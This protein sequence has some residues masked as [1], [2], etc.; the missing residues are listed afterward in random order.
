LSLRAKK[1]A[2]KKAE[3]LQSALTLL[4]D[5]GY[6]GTTMEDI[7]SHLLMTKGALY[8]YFKDKQE[9]VYES[10]IKLLNK[11]IDNIKS[12][13]H[14]EVSTPEKLRQVIQLHV[15]YLVENKAGFELM[16]KPS[17]IFSEQQL[18]EI[19]RLRDRYATY[20]DV[21]L[22]EGVANRSFNVKKD[23]IKIA[24]NLLLG[25]MNWVT[26]WYSPHGSKTVTEF[27]EAVTSYVMRMIFNEDE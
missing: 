22:H 7:A 11:S 2:R 12:V 15:Q 9:L 3:I 19:F 23:E 18:A 25:A 6:H 1:T 8:Y 26:Q 4:A 17:E 27:A 21:L 24:R 10:Q 5:K 20:Y 13:L 16:A 14:K